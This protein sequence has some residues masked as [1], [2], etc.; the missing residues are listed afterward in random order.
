MS[1]YIPECRPQQHNVC[2]AACCCTLHA[3]QRCAA[4]VLPA[5]R[6]TGASSTPLVLF[7]RTAIRSPDAPA[8]DDGCSSMQVHTAARD[9]CSCMQLHT[10]ARG[11]VRLQGLHMAARGCMRLPMAA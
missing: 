3:E 9:A 2:A 6:G 4:L 5:R 1:G 11:C 7:A 10:A 8:Q